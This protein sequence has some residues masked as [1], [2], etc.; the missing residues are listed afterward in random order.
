MKPVHADLEPA[1][2]PIA[3]KREASLLPRL[4][5]SDGSLEALKWFA[6]LLMTL[7]HVNKYLLHESVTTIFNAGRVAM[8]LF[9]FVLAYNLARPGTLESGVYPR[10][11]KRLAISCAIATVPFVALG[12]L[13]WG[14]WPLNIMAT[15]LLAT[16]ALYLI[17]LRA[18]PGARLALPLLLVGGVFVEFWWF[19]LAIVIATWSYSRRPTWPALLLGLAALA[20]LQL[21]NRN[22]WAFAA[23]PLIALAA[24]LPIPIPKLR[25]VFYVFYPAHLA[26]IWVVRE[27][28]FS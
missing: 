17:E 10:V 5:I 18:A 26:L 8:P 3:S 11:M 22:P 21:V 20:S 19:A 27:V 28:F 13:G 9:A 16:A 1:V 15:L 23:L 4:T 14:W 24:N 25:W 12:G 2:A 6:L 7:D